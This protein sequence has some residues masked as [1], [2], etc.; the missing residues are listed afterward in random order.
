MRSLLVDQ[1]LSRTD[2]QRFVAYSDMAFDTLVHLSAFYPGFEQWYRRKV[3]PGL[4][5]GERAVLMRFVEGKLGGIAIVKDT[6]SEKKL[7]CLRVMPHL[8]GSGLGLRLF[9]DSFEVLQSEKPLL[10]VAEE[11]LPLFS[12]VFDHFGFEVVRRYPELYR[13]RS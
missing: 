8:Q 2:P 7:C 10:S 13:P 9:E 12:R 1:S 4:I 11:Q 5:T 3:A 6:D